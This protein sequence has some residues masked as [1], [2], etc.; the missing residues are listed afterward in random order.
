MS[1]RLGR[2]ASRPGQDEI[3]GMSDAERRRRHSHAGAWERENLRRAA[4]QTFG[5]LGDPPRR[6]ALPGRIGRLLWTRSLCSDYSRLPPCWCAMRL[7]TGARGLSWRLPGLV[8]WARLMDFCKARGL[9]GWSRRSGRWWRFIDFDRRGVLLVPGRE[10]GV[11]GRRWRVHSGWGRR[12]TAAP[13][14][15][16]TVY[17]SSPSRAAKL[18]R[19]CL[20]L[21]AP[22]MTVSLLRLIVAVLGVKGPKEY[23]NIAKLKTW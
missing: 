16:L 15:I 22:V 1:G 13:G 11:M 17:A 18:T 7:R 6:I 21:G 10:A 14:Q 23:S 2:S 20:P 19:A 3:P 9:L 12:R 4:R 8:F 5:R